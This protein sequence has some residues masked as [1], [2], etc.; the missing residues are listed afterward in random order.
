MTD[1][2]PAES[3]EIP[4]VTPRPAI[5]VAGAG[6]LGLFVAGCWANADGPVRC[7]ARP[8]LVAKLGEGPLKISDRDNQSLEAPLERL[9][10]THDPAVAF[11]NAQIIF[12]TVKSRHTDAMASLVRAHA[13][14]GAILVSLQNGVRNLERLRESLPAWD[15]RG[16]VVGF[17][18]AW[19]GPAWLHRGV[20]GS[21]VVEDASSEL[22]QRLAAPLLPV[23]A[24][25]PIEPVQWGKLL[26]NLNNGLNA[27]S[28]LALKDQLADRGWRMLLAGAMEE[29]LTVMA[30]GGV[31][32][33]PVGEV[34]PRK[35]LAAMKMPNWLYG[36]TAARR[37][38]IDAEARS[39][40]LD[41]L[42]AG[43]P[44]EI[45]ELQGEILTRARDLSVPAPVNAAV[46]SLIRKA[47]AAGKGSPR[48]SPAQVQARI[49]R[50]LGAR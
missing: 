27:L 32:P 24:A 41:D 34:D 31:A 39:S 22:A 13:P 49:A 2:S 29:A 3:P 1:A 46:L 16:G 14:R 23:V 28:G 15:V 10:L 19:R 25:H 5:S 35:L 36:L 30:R 11:S 48:L 4:A 17:N 21:I 7:L 33:A 6:S 12:V 43:R 47:E 38:K 37:L 20:A 8:A 45:D 9:R 26:M 50:P 18:V 44:T 40:M 42:E